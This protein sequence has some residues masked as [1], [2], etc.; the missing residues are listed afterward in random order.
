MGRGIHRIYSL[1]SSDDDEDFQILTTTLSTP[2]MADH[3]SY[4]M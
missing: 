2:K 3:K 1:D 4:L